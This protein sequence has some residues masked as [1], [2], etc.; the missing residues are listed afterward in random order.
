MMKTSKYSPLLKCVCVHVWVLCQV[1]AVLGCV[2]GGELP[3]S[4]KKQL[5][6]FCFGAMLSQKQ[7]FTCAK[8]LQV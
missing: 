2:A 8:Y 4:L 6:I 3:V 5:N 1:M 7:H